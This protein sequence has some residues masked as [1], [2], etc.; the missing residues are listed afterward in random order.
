MNDRKISQKL[1]NKGY[2]SIEKSITKYGKIKM[3]HKLTF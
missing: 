1:K 2:L 3:L